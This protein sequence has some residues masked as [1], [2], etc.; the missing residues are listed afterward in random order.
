MD[1]VLQTTI[2]KRPSV[3]VRLSNLDMTSRRQPRMIRMP[4]RLSK[5]D[6]TLEHPVRTLSSGTVRMSKT[7]AKKA[8][9]ER[10]TP[11]M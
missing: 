6:T 9:G 5:V 1:R 3:Q 2:W 10:H 4:H 8:E 7:D 11:H